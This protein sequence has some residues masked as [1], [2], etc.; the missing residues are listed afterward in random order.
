MLISIEKSP[1]SDSAG[2]RG[3]AVRPGPPRKL[4]EEEVLDAAPSLLAERGLDGQRPLGRRPLDA[5]PRITSPFTAL[6]AATGQ[7]CGSISRRHRAAEFKNFLT[8][9]RSNGGPPC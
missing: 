6:D 1:S 5:S 3:N 2:L 7:V 8:I 4:T 9:T